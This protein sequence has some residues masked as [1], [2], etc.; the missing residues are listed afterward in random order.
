MVD[1]SPHV[2]VPLAGPD[3]VRDDGS[4]KAETL[5][6]GQPFLP[7]VLGSRSWMA[8]VR[9][10]SLIFVLNDQPITRDFVSRSL[11]SWYPNAGVVFLSRYTNGAASSAL[12]GVAL[13]GAGR[14]PL[15]FDLADI[16]FTEEDD[17]LLELAKLNTGGVGLAFASDNPVYSYLRLGPDGT[18]VEAAEKRVISEWASA[19]VYFFANSSTYLQ[20]LAYAMAWPERHTFKDQFFLCPLF[21]G[22]VASGQRVRLARVSGVC[23]L[24]PTQKLEQPDLWVI[25]SR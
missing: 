13:T 14:G 10:T 7:R 21:N 16:L 11:R 9:E 6:D 19:G 3:F 18:C 5:L 8:H 12:T 22:V 17:P 24:K 15:I 1:V 20:A 23:D 25:E 2:I 4:V